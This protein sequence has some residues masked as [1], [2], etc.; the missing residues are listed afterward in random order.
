[1]SFSRTETYQ[2]LGHRRT[3]VPGDGTLLYS[4]LT[5]N[6]TV[7][8]RIVSN[9]LRFARKP[10]TIEDHARS[11]IIYRDQTIDQYSSLEGLL[12]HTLKALTQWLNIPRPIS[13]GELLPIKDLLETLVDD[14]WLISEN[15]IID[16][17]A[18]SCKRDSVSPPPFS[19]DS[20]GIVTCGRPDEL[21]RCLTTYL[22]HF[23]K[24]D[25]CPRV[26]V[27]DNS[28]SNEARARNVSITEH[29]TNSSPFQIDYLGL[30]ERER[31]ARCISH[32]SGVPHHVARF[33]LLGRDSDRQYGAAR[34][35]LLLSAGNEPILH[36]DDDTYLPSSRPGYLPSP[37]RGSLNRKITLTSD[38]PVDFWWGNHNPF[39]V[40]E[41]DYRTTLPSLL[42]QLETCFGLTNN[43]P[44][45]NR[46]SIEVGQVSYRLVDTLTEKRANT[47]VAH[48]GTVGDSGMH[49][50]HNLSRLTL[51]GD[52]HNRLINGPLSYRQ[53]VN[54][55]RLTRAT[56]SFVLTD[57]ARCM[58]TCAAM[59]NELLLPPFIPTG[60]GE[61]AIFGRML[62]DC[63]K[64]MLFG[65]IP[66]VVKHE[67]PDRRTH[68]TPI[69]DSTFPKPL[70]SLN[71]IVKRLISRASPSYPSDNNTDNLHTTGHNL[72][73][74]AKF[75]DE[76]ITDMILEDMGAALVS[77]IALAE[78]RLT[79]NRDAPEPWRED[80]QR[81]IQAHRATL[82]K[83]EPQEIP[84][85]SPTDYQTG[86]LHT[87]LSN[88][89]D[90]LHCW[91]EMQ[92]IMSNGIADL[93]IAQR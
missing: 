93:D 20:V 77:R 50:N 43:I 81:Y 23:K 15:T 12:R 48:V 52:S 22:R 56:T 16:R 39:Q 58:T 72:G 78:D 91:P 19:L 53:A 6:V 44:V 27:C 21:F 13:R 17:V 34:N 87:L 64:D 38:S 61:D 71:G 57:Q 36:I 89:A 29:I 40:G 42:S 8:S 59:N 68:A 69:S 84:G 85:A 33:A 73:I 76:S 79:K 65:H 35:T 45:H 26:I 25:R 80:L 41:P 90:L 63:Y 9:L 46:K 55:R 70:M 18:Q 60:R 31:L 66:R 7:T 14:G 37:R 82:T 47:A 92:N 3:S 74:I 54:T 83:L 5:G 62:N 86:G 1:M 4:L 67:P 51:T 28:K 11:F 75:G 88:Y 30:S 10:R 32:Q 24:H 49:K 2:S